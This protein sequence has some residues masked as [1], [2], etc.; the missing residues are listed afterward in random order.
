MQRFFFIYKTTNIKT[1]QYYIGKHVTN[2]LDD[3]YIGS[4]TKLRSAI[5]KHGKDC[6]KFEI[7]TFCHSN[8]ELN[9]LEEQIVTQ[10]IVD[11]PLSYNL[12]IGGHGGWDHCPSKG[13]KLSEE[14]RRKMSESRA[15]KPRAKR[16]PMS[17]EDKMWR[18]LALKGRKNPKL[19]EQ[20]T[21]YWDRI[22][23]DPDAFAELKAQRSRQQK[24]RFDSEEF[25]AKHSAG[26][27]RS[28]KT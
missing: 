11:D 4:G 17:E 27:A 13:R 28:K 2:K 23:S 19:S 5:R 20:L 9:L 10:Q 21:E 14:T 24:A 6:F 22:K 1:G 25:R 8:E 16:G 26:V 18:S 3:G 15:G 12:K 7:V